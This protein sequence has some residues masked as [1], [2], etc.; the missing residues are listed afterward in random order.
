M[1][2]RPPVPQ[3]GA[4]TGLRYAPMAETKHFVAAPASTNRKLQKK[5]EG[6][7]SPRPRDGEASPSPK[8]GKQEKGG[9]LE[10]LNALLDKKEK[11]WRQ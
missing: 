11:G 4:L 9:N 7:G 6:E 10:A 3:T 2:S 5:K 1:N 8:R